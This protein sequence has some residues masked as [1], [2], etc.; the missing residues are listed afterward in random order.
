MLACSTTKAASEISRALDLL[1]R[2][3]PPSCSATDWAIRDGCDRLD[4]IDL[5]DAR[6]HTVQD[7]GL[8]A[9]GERSATASGV[10]D[11]NG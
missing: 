4:N 8:D 10:N 5:L 6:R 11:R 1:E 3:P 7:L 9:A 2:H